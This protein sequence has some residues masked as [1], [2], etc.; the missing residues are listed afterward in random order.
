MRV[1]SRALRDRGATLLVSPLTQHRKQSLRNRSLP[2]R[3]AYRICVSSA[4][5]A[6]PTHQDT[7]CTS[8]SS[9]PKASQ[10][11]VEVQSLEVTS[12]DTFGA[13]FQAAKKNN[14][15]GM[16]VFVDIL[17]FGRRHDI[18]T[19]ATKY[20]IPTVAYVREFADAG[21]LLA[22]GANLADMHRRA[23]STGSLKARSPATSLSS[24]QPS[25]SWSST[26]VEP[27]MAVLLPEAR[28]DVMCS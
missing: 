15:S 5:Y 22:Y 2:F 18:T 10:L 7:V 25:S 28:R 9:R 11:H 6:I 21:G 12:P 13:A 1:S 14:L 3:N 27:R 20:R 8:T 24:S 16:I 4:C 23:A 17:T 26:D 19:L